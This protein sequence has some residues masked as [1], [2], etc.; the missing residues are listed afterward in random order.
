MTEKL[1]DKLALVVSFTRPVGDGQVQFQTTVAQDIEDKHLFD[2]MDK[3]HCAGHRMALYDSLEKSKIELE[4]V[5]FTE[6]HSLQEARLLREKAVNSSTKLTT[7]EH[8]RLD[9]AN[10]NVLAVPVVRNKLETAIA[11]IQ[12]ELSE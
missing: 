12:K 2:L 11:R 4:Q 8:T 7:A 10:A 1:G 5:L 3:F 6:N 9:Q